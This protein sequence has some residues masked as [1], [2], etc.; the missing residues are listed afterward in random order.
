MTVLESIKVLLDN[1]GIEYQYMHHETTPTSEDSARV[2]GDSLS[3]GA[4]AIV[5]K[6]QDDFSLFVFAADHKL[7][8]KLIKTYFKQ[9]GKR[10][11]KTRFATSDELYKMTGLVPGSVP[12]F[13]RP[14]LDLELYVDPSLLSNDFISFNAGSLTDSVRMS[15]ADYRQ[16]AVPVVFD[17]TTAMDIE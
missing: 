12:P 1:A 15:L 16:L 6:V 4:K 14:I 13:G 10:V 3:S 5:Y 8:T 9:Q 2:R 11:K 17:F 7:D